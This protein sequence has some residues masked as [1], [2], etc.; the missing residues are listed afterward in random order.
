MEVSAQWERF[1]GMNAIRELPRL[2]REAG[3]ATPEQAKELAEGLAGILDG[4]WGD[5]FD[6]VGGNSPPIRS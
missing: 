1:Y 3:I 5:Q 2:L 6:T 4:G